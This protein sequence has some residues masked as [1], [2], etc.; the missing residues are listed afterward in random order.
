[1][2]GSASRPML[3]CMLT[4]QIL[5]DKNESIMTSRQLSYC[6]T[7]DHGGLDEDE[8]ISRDTSTRDTNP[9]TV[10]AS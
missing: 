4:F 2:L 9:V 7:D 8:K 10:A 3:A 5:P 6:C 1:M